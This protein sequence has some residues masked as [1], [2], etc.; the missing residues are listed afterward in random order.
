MFG[1]FVFRMKYF[2]WVFNKTLQ[3]FYEKS[4][5]SREGHAEHKIEDVCDRNIVRNF[6]LHSRATHKTS[7]VRLATYGRAEDDAT[8]PGFISEPGRA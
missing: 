1:I 7:S 2:I 8:E 4:F 6:F 3:T 5:F